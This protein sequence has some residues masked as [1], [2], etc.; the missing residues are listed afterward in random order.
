MIDKDPVLAMPLVERGLLLNFDQLLSWAKTVHTDLRKPF[1]HA[2]ARRG[3]IKSTDHGSSIFMLEETVRLLVLTMFAQSLRLQ[4][5]GRGV[6]LHPATDSLDGIIDL[7]A[8]FQDYARKYALRAT[9]SMRELWNH[10]SEL[11]IWYRF[12]SMSPEQIANDLRNVGVDLSKVPLD[13]VIEF[14]AQNG[15]HYR[16]YARALREFLLAVAQTSP[17][18]RQRIINERMLEI[19]DYAADLRRISRAAFGIRTATLLIS[20]AGAA[21]TLSRGDPIGALLGGS[22]ASIQALPAAGQDVTAYSYLVRAR[23]DLS[24]A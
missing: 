20:M 17:G 19:Q 22:A 7:S 11:D 9:Y 8:A 5:A 21:W 14:R 2:L 4:L 24:R 15:Q 6:V 13:E 16:L 10:G 23:R 12:D 3:L 18:E 1:Q